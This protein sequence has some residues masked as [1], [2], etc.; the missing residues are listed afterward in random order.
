MSSRGKRKGFGIKDISLFNNA[1]LAKWKWRMMSGHG[2][3]WYHVIKSK[4]GG[5]QNLVRRGGGQKAFVWWKGFF[6]AV[7]VWR[8]CGV[9]EEKG[10]FDSN[11]V[12]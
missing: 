2:G 3:L 9:Y 7:M 6:S 10:W 5:W 1:L 12:W 11:I 8:R 4:Y